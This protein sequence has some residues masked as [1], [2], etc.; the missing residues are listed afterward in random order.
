MVVIVVLV[1]LAALA[2][3]FIGGHITQS[4]RTPKDTSVGTPSDSSD[5]GVL[6]AP[7]PADRVVQEGGW[8]PR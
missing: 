1:V 4:N 2:L 6:C 8:E 3:P 5:C 7:V